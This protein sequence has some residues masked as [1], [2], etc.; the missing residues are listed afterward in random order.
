[1]QLTE[2]HIIKPSHKYYRICDDLAFKSKNLYNYTLYLVRQEFI[3]N[4]KYLP[5]AALQHRLQEEKQA[6]YAALP[7]KVAQQTMK[8]LDRNFKSFFAS[9]KDYAKNP[10]KYNGRPQLPKYLDKTK[11]RYVVTYTNQ[12]VGKRELDKRGVIVPSQTGIEIPTKVKWEQLDCVRIIP[13]NGCYVVEIVYTV[14]EKRQRKDNGRHAGIDLGVSNFATIASNCDDVLPYIVSGMEIKSYNH[15]Y[16]KR[17]AELKSIAEKRNKKKTTIRLSKLERDRYNRITD[18]MHKASRHVVNRLVSDRITVL[19]IGYN[20]SWKQDTD[21]KKVNNQNFCCIPHLQFVQMLEYKCRMAGIKCV[22]QE[23]S[24]T[25]KCSFLDGEEICHHEKYVGR[26]RKRGLFVAS[27]GRKINADVNG[28]LNILRKCKPIGECKP[29]VWCNGC[30][31]H[32]V[33]VHVWTMA[34]P[35]ER[36]LAGSGYL[37]RKLTGDRAYKRIGFN[38]IQVYK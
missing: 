19:V 35:A 11:G 8:L 32:P 22:R 6:D 20:E 5:Y 21:M 1:M 24:H 29:P 31:V 3:A 2:R 4:G 12:A 25:S 13:K 17:K 30:V 7:A 23:E 26:R 18:F 27:D 9:V 15:W 16:N 28:A 38:E 10:S 36:A 33:I 37:G 14:Q 34:K